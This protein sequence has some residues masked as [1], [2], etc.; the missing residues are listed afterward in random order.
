MPTID[1]VRTVHASDPAAW[2]WSALRKFQNVELAST[3]ITRLQNIDPRWSK[4]VR[5]QARQIRY[6]MIQAREYFA[7][8]QG[9]SIATKPNLLYYGAMSL[10]LAEILLKQ[11]GD[12]SLD[13]ARAEHRHHGLL[14]TAGEFSLDASLGVSAGAL[15]AVPMVKS[16]RRKGTFELW[17]RTSREHPL[18]GQIRQHLPEGGSTESF[19]I[20]LGAIDTGYPPL[21]EHGITLAEALEAIPMLTEQA[22]EAGLTPRF[23]RGRCQREEWPGDQWRFE[24]HLTFHPSSENASLL[25]KVKVDARAVNRMDFH[26]IGEGLHIVTRNDALEV[27]STPLPPAAMVSTKE[28]RMWTNDPALN[29]FGYLY[30]ALFIAGNYARYFPD[31]W[32]ADVEAS[33]PLSLAIEQLCTLAEWR[34]PW[35]AL[36]ELD[37][38]LLVNDV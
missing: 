27:V 3:R 28:W 33:T 10:A 13:R 23:V 1:N 37:G 17:H 38:V 2:A 15:R 25:E 36:C 4:N 24:L 22:A 31:R 11:S 8:A 5:K 12:S 32:L 9:V 18:A 26:E 35:L 30:T 16:G 20:L 14:M 34:V 6:C 19:R 21:P 29:E 7:A